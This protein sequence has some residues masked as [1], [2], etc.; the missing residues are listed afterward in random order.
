MAILARV[1]TVAILVARLAAKDLA[2]EF[3][4]AA[5]DNLLHDRAVTRR[6]A[7]AEFLQVGGAV[8]AKDIGHFE[9]ETLTAPP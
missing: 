7:F 5:S 4:G 9:F 8:Q 1:I 2:A 3:F 6:H